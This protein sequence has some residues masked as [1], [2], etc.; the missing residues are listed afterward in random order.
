M[1][2]FSRSCRPMLLILGLPPR[3]EDRLA[4]AIRGM[5]GYGM[6][7]CGRA[8]RTLGCGNHS[9]RRMRN[10]QSSSEDLTGRATSRNDG[11]RLYSK[12]PTA[13]RAFEADDLPG[14]CHRFSTAVDR[15]AFAGLDSAMPN[16]S[17]GLAN[18]S[19]SFLHGDDL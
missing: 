7:A 5:N 6:V 10:P 16:Y 4:V 8:K 13:Q 17:A 12:T 9:V 3:S 2:E 1:S 18:F 11:T 19:S 14:R 15:A